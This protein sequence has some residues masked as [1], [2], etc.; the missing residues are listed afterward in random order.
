IDRG[1]I[2][3]SSNIQFNHAGDK[4]EQVI[5]PI[6]FVTLKGQTSVNLSYLL[7]NDERFRDIWFY[8][9][10]RANIFV[11]SRPID[12]VSLSFQGQIGKFIYRSDSPVMGIGHRFSATLGLKPTSRFNISFSYDRAR[13][14]DFDAD[15]L[16]YDGNI[17]RSTITYQFTQEIFIRT[18]AQYNSFGKSLNFYP[19]FNYKLNAFTTFFAGV[20]NDYYNYGGERGF[21][22]T[23]RQYFVKVQ[24]LF[25][26]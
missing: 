26:H 12:E 16:F 13:L 11:N 21:T 10:N 14:S 24:Y 18:I 20:T 6:L 19:L 5:Q 8:K 7:V 4:K 23:D 17:Y 3:I 25:R 22:T 15:K 9:V 2:E 1:G